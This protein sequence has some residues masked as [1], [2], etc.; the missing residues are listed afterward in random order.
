MDNK[1][2]ME[3]AEMSYQA[4]ADRAGEDVF[5]GVGL[6]AYEVKMGKARTVRD[7][8]QLLRTQLTAALQERDLVD[9]QLRELNRRVAD[10]VRGHA[11]HGPNSPLYRAMGYVP[12]S[13]RGSGLTRR[14]ADEGELGIP[15][16]SSNGVE[17]D[18][19]L[20]E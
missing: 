14:S 4:W 10:G 6:A 12:D 15:V 9:L 8:V 18:L 11:G 3:R 16:E 17:D 1:Q 5:S 2:V 13:E 20:A 7:K 19:A